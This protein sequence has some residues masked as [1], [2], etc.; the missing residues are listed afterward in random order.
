MAYKTGYGSTRKRTCT[1][2]FGYQEGGSEFVL[3]AG[4]CYEY[5]TGE[6]LMFAGDPGVAGEFNNRTTIISRGAHFET[7]ATAGRRISRRSGPSECDQAR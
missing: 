6:P 2:G 5:N 4:H 1:A 7:R 3:T